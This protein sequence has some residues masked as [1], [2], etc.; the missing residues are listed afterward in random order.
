MD[1]HE[2]DDSWRQKDCYCMIALTRQLSEF[3]TQVIAINKGTSVLR[4]TVR[5]N[6]YRHPYKSKFL[7]K[8]VWISR[9]RMNTGSSLKTEY[10]AIKMEGLP[11]H[12]QMLLTTVYVTVTPPFL[13]LSTTNRMQHH[14][15]YY[16]N[17]VIMTQPSTSLTADDAPPF[18]QQME[19]IKDSVSKF[20]ASP[21]SRQSAGYRVRMFIFSS[22]LNSWQLIHTTIITLDEGSV[23]EIRQCPWQLAYFIK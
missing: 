18:T 13:I 1:F 12:K 21:L 14:Y 5:H 6:L 19:Y 3:I 20:C 8:Y 23:Y 22:E 7:L 17:F 2:N 16:T 15:E 9:R 10:S 4:I 11:S